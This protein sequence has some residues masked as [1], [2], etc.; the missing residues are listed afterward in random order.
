MSDHTPGPWEPS[1]FVKENPLARS[2]VFLCVQ[3]A[4]TNDTKNRICTIIAQG[5]GRYDPEVTNAN[6]RI[7]AAAPEL[8]EVL[9]N[10]VENGC[11]ASTVLKDVHLVKSRYV[12][13]AYAIIAKAEGKRT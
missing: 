5:D 9:K 4:G 3:R 7:L 13:E 6:A 8:L 10:I 2:G 12:E 11:M 1:E